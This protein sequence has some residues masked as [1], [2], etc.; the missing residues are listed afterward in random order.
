VPR[1]SPDLDDILERAE[2]VFARHGYGETSLRQLL[3][4]MKIS[5]TA[6]Y[7]RFGSKEDVLAA[8]VGRMLADLA[9]S[10]AGAISGAHTLEEGF[11]RGADAL[12]RTLKDHRIVAKGA[13]AEAAGAPTV[14]TTLAGAYTTLAG[15]LAARIQH[16]QQRGRIAPADAEALGWALVGALQIQVMRWAVFDELDDAGLA[17]ALRRGARAL[18]PAV[19]Q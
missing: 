19:K 13:L 1:P 8:L 16:L 17:R 2:R 10:T 12:I 5:T 6:F 7:A 18:L 9:T 11:D 14:R 3:A 15:L 4:G